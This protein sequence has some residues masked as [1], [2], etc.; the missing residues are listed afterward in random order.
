MPVIQARPVTAGM[1]AGRSATVVSSTIRPVKRVPMKDSLTKSAPTSSSPLLCSTAIR[2]HVPVP[3]GDRSNQPGW[4]AIALRACPPPR[5]GAVNWTCL[6]PLMFASR[7]C[8]G[9]AV[10][11]MA[12]MMDSPA[13]R[14]RSFSLRS[15]GMPSCASG[16]M[17]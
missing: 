10:V 7:R 17:A 2:A 13:A 9:R 15:N 8:T 12:S 4:M 5:P 3:Q 14:M 1:I 11:L 16:R 6:Q